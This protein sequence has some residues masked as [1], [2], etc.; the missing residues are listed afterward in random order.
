MAAVSLACNCILCD[1]ENAPLFVT[2]DDGKDYFR[3]PEC[4]LIFLSPAQRLNNKDELERYLTHKND[5]WD[6]KYQEF[7]RPVSDR[8]RKDFPN[9]AEGL[10]FGSGKNSALAL[11]LNHWGYVTDVY[12][13]YFFPN[14]K[15]L[16]I[17]HEFITAT[18]VIEHLY[19]PSLEFKRLEGLLKP[20]GRLY[21][22]TLIYNPEQDFR[23]WWYRRD[24]THVAFYTRRC[25]E[26]IQRIF[27]FQSLE[28]VSDR[29]L[30]LQ[31]TTESDVR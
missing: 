18:E 2:C 4:D 20:G 8:V 10:D 3:C 28:I 9:G 1:V 12:D 6:P 25:L 24:P 22:M 30:V 26:N 7:V 29:F 27:K 15:A 23:T 5:A 17:S 13:P 14:E 16:K 21:L 19:Q 11:V 31:K